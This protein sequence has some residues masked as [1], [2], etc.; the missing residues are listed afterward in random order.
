[1]SRLL[2]Y[3]EYAAENVKKCIKLIKIN[4]IPFHSPSRETF[5]L[6]MLLGDNVQSA[7]TIRSRQ[8]LYVREFSSKRVAGP[9]TVDF[10]EKKPYFETDTFLSL[11]AYSFS[12]I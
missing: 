8:L 6:G 9:N 3:F 7:S 5:N 1:M 11:I 4:V 12:T 2:I 10:G